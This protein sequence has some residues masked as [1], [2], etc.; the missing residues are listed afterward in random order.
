MGTMG[1]RAEA[2]S[3]DAHKICKRIRTLFPSF[4]KKKNWHFQNK[5]FLVKV[6]EFTPPQRIFHSFLKRIITI[7]CSTKS[8]R[9]LEVMRLKF[10]N[11]CWQI[12]WKLSHCS[13]PA[14]STN[15]SAFPGYPNCSPLLYIHLNSS[16]RRKRT[17][18][19]LI[20]WHY[21]WL[22]LDRYS[23]ERVKLIKA[24]EIKLLLYYLNILFF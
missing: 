18:N 4:S 15:N 1:G 7:F 16:T 12:I 2:F 24:N 13:Y 11:P 10:N 21:V 5:F 23:N 9:T 20:R 6:T 22:S 19:Q 17:M 3:R 8:E 14:I